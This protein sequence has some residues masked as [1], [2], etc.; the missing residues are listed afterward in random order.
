MFV[1]CKC[2]TLQFIED[3]YNKNK[4][5]KSIKIVIRHGRYSL[6]DFLFLLYSNEYIPLTKPPFKDHPRPKSKNKYVFFVVIVY[7]ERKP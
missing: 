7:I 2:T 5:L 1:L 6:P 4:T 3:I